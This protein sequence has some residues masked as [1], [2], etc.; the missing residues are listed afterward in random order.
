MKTAKLLIVC[1]VAA[2][3][4]QF[5]YAQSG[6]LSLGVEV[7]QPTGDFGDFVGTGIGGSLRYEMPL[8]GKLG[9]G[10][11]AGYIAFGGDN[12]G[13]TWNLIPIQA[14]GKFYLGE[15]QGGLYGQV[16]LGVHSTSVEDADGET[17]A[18]WALGLGYHMSKLDLGVRWQS[19]EGDKTLS[20]VGLRAAYVFGS[21]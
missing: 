20:Y 17:N 18:S 12:D 9:I 7:A 5:T 16:D 4:S 11:T 14:F 13:P 3:A 8:L 21:R 6:R 15:N 10:L 2:C 1:L 19:V